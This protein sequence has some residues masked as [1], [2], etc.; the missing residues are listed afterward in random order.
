MFHKF[1]HWVEHFELLRHWPRIIFS[2]QTKTFEIYV[3]K[4]AWVV[5]CSCCWK[6]WTKK[7]IANIWHLFS[8]PLLRRRLW[9]KL[10]QDE[11][12]YGEVSQAVDFAELGWGLGPDDFLAPLE[13]LLVLHLAASHNQLLVL[14]GSE[15]QRLVNVLNFPLP[16]RSNWG[17]CLTNKNTTS[18]IYFLFLSSPVPNPK[19]PRPNPN[20]VPI[21]SETKRDWGLH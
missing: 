6:L 14:D 7:A 1:F 2:W 9:C 4:Y 8:T 18:N 10:V 5:L 17:P 19:P 20:Q 3:P 13:L 15:G 11:L 16:R 12:G 21:R